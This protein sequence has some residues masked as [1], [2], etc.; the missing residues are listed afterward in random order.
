M[1]ENTANKDDIDDNE[2]RLKTATEADD[3]LCLS[4]MIL[5]LTPQ[6]I[7]KFST[8]RYF[9]DIRTVCNQKSNKFLDDVTNFKLIVGQEK[10]PLSR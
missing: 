6:K 8:S 10:G 2:T 4:Q 5:T 3:S 7:L 9:K 1:V